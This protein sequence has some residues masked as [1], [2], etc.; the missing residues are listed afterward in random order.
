MSGQP[1]YW[2]PASVKLTRPACNI[3]ES[4]WL[5]RLEMLFVAH[6]IHGLLLT[7][8]REG[9]DKSVMG[10]TILAGDYCFSHSAVLATGTESPQV[11]AIFAQA[12]KTV[13]EGNSPPSVWRTG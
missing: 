7:A 2:L 6:S 12:L 5:L 11:V 4:N 13:S 10:S 9:M 8:V 3:S 1:L